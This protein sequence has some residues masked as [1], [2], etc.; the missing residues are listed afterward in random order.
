MVALIYWLF[1]NFGTA[2]DLTRIAVQTNTS[3]LV[4]TK[5]LVLVTIRP[6]TSKHYYHA[7]F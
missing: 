2:I 1:Q 7:I 4:C 3:V 5:K 6:C